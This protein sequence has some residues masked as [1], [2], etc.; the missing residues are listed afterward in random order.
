MRGIAM[1]VIETA[2][3]A[4]MV[5]DLFREFA[6]AQRNGSNFHWVTIPE[7]V[8]VPDPILFDPAGMTALYDTGYDA[9]LAGPQWLTSPPGMLVSST[10]AE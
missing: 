8:E 10:P 4:G 1:R 9:A 5:G 7:D 2:G 3:R 6:I